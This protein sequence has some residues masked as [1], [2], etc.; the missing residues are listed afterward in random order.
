MEAMNVGAGSR[1]GN[2]LKTDQKGYESLRFMTT[3]Y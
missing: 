2:T 1:T 3:F